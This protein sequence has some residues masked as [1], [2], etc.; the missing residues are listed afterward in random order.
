MVI[1]NEKQEFAEVGHGNMNWGPIIEA[2]YE[3]GIE[4]VAIEQDTCLGDPFESLKM[5]YEFLKDKIK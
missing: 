2:C 3:T 4:Y 1:R 5:S